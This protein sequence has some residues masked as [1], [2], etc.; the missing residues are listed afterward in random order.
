MSIIGLV[1]TLI[2]LGVVMWAIN[3]FIPMEP[4]IKT[5]ANVVV[6]IAI[7]FWLAHSFGLINGGDFHVR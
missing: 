3:A 7:L 6:I 4:K 2:V 1:L 5:L